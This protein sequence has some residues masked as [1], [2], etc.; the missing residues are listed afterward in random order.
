M[1]KGKNIRLD[2]CIST[3]VDNTDYLLDRNCSQE[4]YLTIQNT[5]SKIQFGK[6]LIYPDKYISAVQQ[7]Y[8]FSQWTY[9]KIDIRIYIV[10][11]NDISLKFFILFH[12]IFIKVYHLK[13]CFSYKKKSKPYLC[14]PVNKIICQTSRL[15]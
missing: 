12:W 4:E 7:I 13:R 15:C 3:I 9:A 6:Y 14:N 2:N 8:T 1:K 11:L 10:F 5:K